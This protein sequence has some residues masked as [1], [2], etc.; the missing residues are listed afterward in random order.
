MDKNISVFADKALERSFKGFPSV[1]M[2]FF[3][4]V[5]FL[6][7]KKAEDKFQ[8]IISFYS[9]IQDGANEGFMLRTNAEQSDLQKV[10]EDI[11]IIISSGMFGDNLKINPIVHLFNDREQ[12]IAMFNIGS[13]FDELET[14]R[15]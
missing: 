6:V 15:E 2:S 7:L 3:K 9:K 4:G 14:V 1:D 11:G 10:V 5:E 12:A 13:L 8:L